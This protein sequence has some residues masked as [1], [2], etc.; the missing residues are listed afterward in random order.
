[1]LAKTS[2]IAGV[3]LATL[4]FA[5]RADAQSESESEAKPPD[6]AGEGGADQLV[7]QKGRLVINGFIE[8]DLSTDRVFKPVSISP[9]A[10]YGIT[11]DITAGLVHSSV[12]TTGFIGG[13]G[14][15]LCLTGTD[16]GCSD[17]YPGVGFVGRY[18]L[19][20]SGFA[21]AAEGGL[22]VGHIS[23]PTFLGLKLGGIGRW[24][25]NKLAVEVQPSL[26]IGVTNRD[27]TTTGGVVF[28]GNSDVLAL[29]ATAL[30]QITPELTAAA[31]T[32]F[33]IPLE[34]TGDFYSIP[35][36][37]GGFYR[38]NGEVTVNM[39]FSLPLLIAGS[40]GGLDAR[41]LTLGGTY[42][43]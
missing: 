22:I 13:T 12:G 29:P 26:Y 36:S 1:M 42:A 4:L 7:L 39:A 43:F 20:V 41:S 8:I 33:N 23:D 40:S 38:L 34:N 2:T 16:N 11:D 10:W 3:A 17:L 31:Q 28:A 15:S 37:I 6:A 25:K 18:R 30:Y 19:K 21:V 5:A 14:D 32:G 9:D 24:H 27:S 35:L